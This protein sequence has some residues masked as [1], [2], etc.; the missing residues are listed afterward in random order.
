MNLLLLIDSSLPKFINNSINETIMKI[1]S[2]MN[3]VYIR[4]KWL[5]TII[6]TL[7]IFIGFS[8][9]QSALGIANP[10]ATYCQDLGYEWTIEKTEGGEI[11]ICKFPDGTAV[12]EW[13]FLKG[14]SGEEWSY[15]KQKG[16][17]LKTLSDSEKCSSIYSEDCAI[18]VLEEGVEI[19]AS[20]LLGFETKLESC[21]NKICDQ[22]ENLQNCPQ[23]C[24]G[25]KKPLLLY[26]GI[27][28]IVI[29]VSILIY[30]GIKRRREKRAIEI[31]PKV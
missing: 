11:G 6:V 25:K 20:K 13:E 7:T 8:F 14:K 24:L 10:A 17:V 4:K 18:C 22:G 12:E 23:D 27:L 28:L 19:E 21:G 1:K 9:T 15:C 30:R 29:L 3:T 5:K 26:I 16:Y 2:K 31:T